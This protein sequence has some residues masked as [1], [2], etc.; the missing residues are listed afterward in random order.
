MNNHCVFYRTDLKYDGRVCAIIQT[1]AMAFPNDQILLYEYPV[2]NDIYYGFPENVKIIKSKLVVGTKITSHF[3]QQL[4]ALIYAIN[5]FIFLLRKRPKT[6][7]VHHEV[8]I[9]G[10]IIYKYL[11]KN[12]ILLYDDKEMY[13]PRDKNIPASFY[14]LEYL[15]IKLSDIV[16]ITNEFRR[17]ALFYIHK[18]NVKKHLIIDNFVFQPNG[19]IFSENILDEIKSLK[20]SNYKIL[21][22]QGVLNKSRGVDLLLKTVKTLPNNWILCFIG[23]SS[24]SFDEFSKYLNSGIKLNLRNMGYIDYH[25]LNSFYKLV[26]ASVMFYDTSTFNNKYCAPN[27]LY[28]AVNNGLP[29]IVN[30]GNHTLND[31]INKKHNGISFK[32]SSSLSSFFENFEEYKKNADSL[33]GKY[34]YNSIIPV[35]KD[36]YSNL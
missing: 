26:D 7:Q 17:K 22:H 11:F 4:K 2:N 29:I 1:L 12:N 5:S 34:E 23:I 21:I 9:L 14:S 28:S 10:S 19:Q 3:I 18:N 33:K 6:I 27:R 36:Y 15:I 35:L 13:H 31:F 16:I 8:T 32:D 24:L 25:E 20:D 30:N